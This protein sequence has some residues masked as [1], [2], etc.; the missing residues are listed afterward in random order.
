MANPSKVTYQLI[1]A[2]ANGVA[3]AQQ[4]L[5]AGLLVLNGSL[6]AGVPAKA[7]FDTARRVLVSST[8]NDAGVTFTIVGTDRNGN[9]QTG[10]VTG[11]VSG[12]PVNSAQDF[13]TVTAVSSGAGTI[14]NIT[15][16]TSGAGSTPWIQDN[17]LEPAWRLA[18]A[19]LGPAGTNYT[20][21]HTYDDFNQV[22]TGA[23]YG[24]SLEAAS[25]V[26][27]TAWPNPVIANV[28]GSNEAR[29]VDWPVYGHR[30]T[31]VSGTGLVT[32][33][34]MQTGIGDS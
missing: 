27:P 15:V 24:F 7:T 16:G 6:T 13:L 3:L 23:P 2:V 26:P 1:A 17:W 20:V 19:C 12:A 30:L 32:M 9:V 33:W 10:T 11:V 21:E 31:I 25:N 14:G 4:P 28:S 29:Y 18:V 34:S 8:G 5:A 22:S